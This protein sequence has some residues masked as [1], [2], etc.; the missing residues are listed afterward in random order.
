[1]L[2]KAKTDPAL[3]AKIEEHLK[4]IGMDTPTT[5]DLALFT[6]EQ[7]IEQIIPLVETISS[8]LGLDNTDDSLQD[9]PRRWAKMMVNELFGG[10]S[11]DMFPKCT[12]IDNKMGY[13][14]MVCETDI[15]VMSTC[16]HHWVTI[17][18]L[19]TVAYI[20]NRKVLG[21]SKMNRIVEYFSRR[22]QVQER[23]TI[24]IAEALKLILE[25]NDVAVV[26]NAKHY[27]VAA[28]GV[29]DR[30]SYTQTSHL[31]GAFKTDKALRQEFFALTK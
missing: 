17:D 12:A 31:G 6:N 30:S 27:C 20:P 13:D 22:P 16:E 29:E 23:L 25:T 2:D 8:I 3:G 9:T 24:Q 1:M 18:G 11:P 10:L 19:A 21:L 14:E 28:R 4:T 26:I 5:A 7:K 15:S